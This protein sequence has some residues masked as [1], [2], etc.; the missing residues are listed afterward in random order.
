MNL[1]DFKILFESLPG[2]YLVLDP[3]LNIAAV[4]DAYLVTTFTDRN[5]ILNRNFF[6]I[7]QDNPEDSKTN[8][9]S[10]AR[11]S[12][13]Q[14]METKKP[15]TVM[16]EKY[17]LRKPGL[18]S[19]EFKE[20]NWSV[21]NTPI[22]NSLGEVLLILVKVEVSLQAQEIQEVTRQLAEA[23]GELTVRRQDL[24]NAIE[25]MRVA[26]DEAL[27]ASQVKSQF[28][29]NM[30]HEIR[31]PLGIILGFTELLLDP[32]LSARE[33]DG[34]ISRI[35]S[36]GQHLLG[37]L[38][39]I[40]D[41]TKIES[42]RLSVERSYFPMM[43][44][45]KEIVA[46][47][48]PSTRK[49]GLRLHL[50]TSSDVPDLLFTDQTKLRQ[51][52]LNLISNAVKFCENG[53]ITLKVSCDAATKN[54]VFS[55]VDCGHGIQPD[56]V[57]HLFEQFSQ[58][59][60]SMTRKHGGSGL[61]LALSRKLAQALGGDIT[62]TETGVKGSTFTLNIPDSNVGQNR[63][64]KLGSNHTLNGKIPQPNA[65]A[66]RKMNILLV[67]D[68]P[69]NLA[70]VKRILEKAGA[71]VETASNGLEGVSKALDNNFDIVLM[72][73][74]MPKLNGYEATTRLREKGYSKPIIA[75]TAHAM[76]EDQKKCLLSGCN[77]YLAK[78]VVGPLLVN[79]IRQATGKNAIGYKVS[80]T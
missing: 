21:I 28:L 53:S 11:A 4:S 43:P 65:D 16:I 78:P 10:N 79:A 9:V 30:S 67:D 31:T 57:S 17:D 74:Q 18:S 22:L 13:N 75:L 7:F 19:R 37:L 56:Y 47:M 45:L 2:S 77:D 59:D 34:Y 69:D 73:I 41:L 12:L 44:F 52:L 33:R 6:E 60:S 35:R 14:V 71:K 55:V 1:A 64:S 51:I 48:S 5:E 50:K 32:A 61:G 63:N 24:E 23:R 68:A 25:N 66:L 36:S 40:L 76:K 46:F 15:N 20:K 38:S 27:R 42:G 8:A 3:G 70:L 29:A 26:K 80:H 72:D 39:E 54:V 62:L 58:A 49:K